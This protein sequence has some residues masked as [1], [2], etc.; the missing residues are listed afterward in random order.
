MISSSTSVVIGL[1]ISQNII[2]HV[3]N[4]FDVC[5]GNIENGMLA[6]EAVFH[7][8][9]VNR[10]CIDLFHCAWLGPVIKSAKTIRRYIDP[11][12]AFQGLEEIVIRLLPV[13]IHKPFLNEVQKHAIISIAYMTK[14]KLFVQYGVEVIKVLWFSINQA[15][16]IVKAKECKADN[17]NIR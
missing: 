6:L 17:S 12:M 8:I 15:A 3:K 14:P 5:L 1:R 9:F 10:N 11:I 2:N 16:R 7:H 13:Q 4:I